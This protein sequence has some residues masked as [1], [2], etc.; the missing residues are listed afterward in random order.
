MSGAHSN[1]GMSGP[2]QKPNGLCNLCRPTETYVNVGCSKG[3]AE[4]F[5]DRS[6]DELPYH[7]Q[8]SNVSRVLL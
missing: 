2:I 4:L 8:M 1:P 7:V 6:V 3:P 5:A